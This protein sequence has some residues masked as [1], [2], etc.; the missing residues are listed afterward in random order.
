MNEGI[1]TLR[2]AVRPAVLAKYLGQ[3]ALVLALLFLLPLA[4]SLF[5]A[6]YAVSLRYLIISPLLILVFLLSR[7]LPTPT[8]IQQNEAL[9]IIALAFILSPLMS[10]IIMH[11]C[12]LEWS[13]ALFESFSA[14][15]TT[16]L[17]TLKAQQEYPHTFLFMRAW[18]QW[19]GGLGIVVF[20]IALMAG[21]HAAS[22]RLAEPPVG[23]GLAITTRTYARHI[24]ITYIIL[25]VAAITLLRISGMAN[26][27]ALTHALAAVSTGGFSPYD[28]SLG[29]FST[30]V[31]ALTAVTIGLAGATPLHL[32]YRFR[33]RGLRTTFQDSE[34]RALLVLALIVSAVLS[35]FF[36]HDG[37]PWETALFH[38]VIQGVSAQSTTGFS[39]LDIASLDADSKLVLIITMF[40]GGGL[41]STAGGIKLLRLLILLRLIQLIVQRTALPSHAITQPRFADRPLGE[42]DIQGALL[43]ILLFIIVIL[44]SWLVFIS[45]GYAPIDSLFEV[46]SASGT[47]G[48]SSGITRGE[49]EPV[50]QALL[51]FDMLLGRLEIIALLVVLYPPTWLA[52][53]TESP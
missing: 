46:V 5:Y 43:L 15:T 16:G 53:R 13:T 1:H 20:S 21:H 30:T 11:A 3:L 6:E 35:L 4:V 23:E 49:L 50:L 42:G 17:T 12:G 29:H 31:P 28:N 2:Q 39:S 8:Q 19:Y 9:T 32:Y 37:M 44:V 25:T 36:Y 34:L 26:F 47:V 48:L 18:M 52:K 14:I 22:R 33:Q 51:C 40:I 27:D 38:G 41:G 45:Y 7:K 24:L 10:S